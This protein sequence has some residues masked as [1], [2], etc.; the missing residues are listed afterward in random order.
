VDARREDDHPDAEEE[1]DKKSRLEGNDGEPA[2]QD[3][4]ASQDF[5]Q[6]K[7]I[8]RLV[9]EMENSFVAFGSDSQTF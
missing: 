1:L 9:S 2:A 7:E 3:N 6:R 5:N 8:F 4:T